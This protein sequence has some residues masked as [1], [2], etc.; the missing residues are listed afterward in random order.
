MC[1]IRE[2]FEETG[3]LLAKK[4]GK[5]I[6]VPEKVREETRKLVH[7]N[8]IKFGDWVKSLGAEPDT[9][10]FKGIVIWYIW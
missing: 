8:K 5:L 2:T 10:I 7:G 4:D 1:A 6:D 3:I 9:G